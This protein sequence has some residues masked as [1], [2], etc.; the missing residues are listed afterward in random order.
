[1]GIFEEIEGRRKLKEVNKTYEQSVNYAQRTFD[2]QVDAIK[3]IK[4]TLGFKEIVTYFERESDSCKILLLGSKDIE[5]IRKVQMKYEIVNN[6][7]SFL[8]S[9][10]DYIPDVESPI[11]DYQVEQL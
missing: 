3:E 11:D 8:T 7:M 10:L 2:K 6:F 1:M 5:E 4:G 9:R